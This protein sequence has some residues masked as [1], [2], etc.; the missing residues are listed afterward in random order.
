M[1]RVVF[2]KGKQKEFLRK[3]QAESNLNDESIAK[4]CGICSRSFRDWRREKF[5]MTLESAKTLSKK[6]KIEMP[7]IKKVLPYWWSK[8]RREA[9]RRGGLNCF[10]KYGR[11]GGDPEYQKKKWYEWWEKEGKYKTTF[12]TAPK[13]IQEPVFSQDLA[14]FVGI[15]LGDG[16]ITQRQITITLHRED[17]REYGK[18]VVALIKRLFNVPVGAYYSR[19]DPV[20]NF[21]V[22]RIR[23]VRFCIEKL[24]LKQGNKIK[25]QVDIPRWIKQNEL[26]SIVCARGLVD[27]DGCV[28]TH[29]YKVNGKL[30]SYKKLCFTS[31]SRP[32]RQSMFNILKVN[33]LNPRLAQNRDVRLDSI[34]DIQK[35]FQV[36]GSHNPKHLKRF[37]N[38]G[39]VA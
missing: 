28:F 22:S 24:G 10:K 1:F 27:T 21:V 35:Y 26:Y 23:L 4:L 15:V 19:K 2:C 5:Y 8:F 9:C 29:S 12:L 25:Q 3:A 37:R 16:S 18:F 31:Y 14:E 39:E 34:K 32:L 38:R 33:G 36:I 30:Y 13:P 6:F 17:D 20:V 11:V 7:R